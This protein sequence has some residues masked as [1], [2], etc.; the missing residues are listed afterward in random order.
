MRCP[1][2]NFYPM[3]EERILIKGK[4]VI[5]RTCPCCKHEEDKK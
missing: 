2:C 4:F 5:A 3:R 1:K